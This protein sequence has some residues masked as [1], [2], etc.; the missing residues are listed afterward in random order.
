MGVRELGKLVRK[1][2][3]S[4]VT[5]YTSLRPFAG[6]RLAIDANLLTTKFHYANAGKRTPN[7][8]DVEPNEGHRHVRAWFYFLEALR[9]QDIQPVVVFDGETRVKEKARENERRRKARELQRLRAAAEG[10]RGDRLREIREVWSRVKDGDRVAVVEGFRQAV[11][12][13]TLEVAAPIPLA[14]SGESGDAAA[15]ESGESADAAAREV[16]SPNAPLHAP[17]LT[18]P[19]R[20]AAPAAP[21]EPETPPR[22][23][24]VAEE[25]AAV[26][27]VKD[28]APKQLPPRQEEA[29]LKPPY[30]APSEP[31]LAKVASAPPRNAAE[32]AL[33]F[34]LASEAAAA[35]LR[36]ER[37]G[38]ITSLVGAAS[39]GTTAAHVIALVSLFTAYRSDSRNPVYSKNQVLVTNDE[40][41]FFQSILRAE[42]D[43]EFFDDPALARN[44]VELDDIIARSDKLGESHSKRSDAVPRAAFE[45]VRKLV[46][47]LGIPFLE[48]SPAEPHEAEGV[49]SALHAL[50]L[51]DYVVSEDTDVAVY[52]APLLRKISVTEAGTGRA[53]KEPMNILDPVTLRSELGLTKE[54]FVDFALLC[55]TDFTERIPGVGPV[56]AL[57]L[58]RQHSTIEAIFAASDGKLSPPDGDIAAYLQTVRD[59]RAIFLSLPNLP[60]SSTS[61]SSAA[62]STDLLAPGAAPSSFAG[63]LSPSPPSPAL[64]ALLRS[65]GI[66][67]SRYNLRAST[68]APASPINED[69]ERAVDEVEGAEAT[70]A[71][72][73]LLDQWAAGGAERDAEAVQEALEID[74]S[75]EEPTG[76]ESDD[77][78]PLAA[79]G[80]TVRRRHETAVSDEFERMFLS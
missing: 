15:R 41:A 5:S 62:T 32:V 8:I 61:S 9:K 22:T 6:K 25:P 38:R 59:A 36:L 37:T 20:P 16:V 57:K 7:G 65:Y 17:A 18:Q 19:I 27:P 79:D 75:E 77:S 1:L 64:P 55:G 30:L 78:R 39:E 54:E 72:G 69:G 24:L 63:S 21:P 49:C 71:M 4:S 2:A 50:G 29:A 76:D 60:L 80:R 45:E 3:P 10:D 74:V 51:I 33:P 43:V 70:A 34:D 11:E 31:K 58:I 66:T 40:G 46:G 26:E 12:E 28:A 35:G 52:G 56:N 23:P 44:D 47:A 53:P 67:R 73:V 13:I 42:I 48:P 68:A 14:E